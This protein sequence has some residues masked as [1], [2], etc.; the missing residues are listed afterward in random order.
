MTR[1]A[2]AISRAQHGALDRLVLACRHQPRRNQPGQATVAHQQVV[3]EADKEARLAR[4]ALAPGAA[5]QLAVHA[6]ALVAIGPDHQQSAQRQDAGAIGLVGTPQAD[7]GASAGHVGGDGHGAVLAGPR[8]DRRFGRVVRCVQHLARHA[9]IT[10]PRRQAVGLL[11][12]QRAH[13]HRPPAAMFAH[14]FGDDGPVLGLA[15]REDHVGVIDAAGGVVRG[16]HDH[17]AAVG[18][19]QL[20]GRALRGAGHPC[21]RGIAAQEPLQRQRCH[22]LTFGTGHQPLLGIEG[23][24]QALRPSPVRHGTAGHLVDHLDA[25]VAHQ[26]VHA[27]AQQR[28]GVQGAIHLAQPEIVAGLVQ[29]AGAERA[30]DRGQP[31]VGQLRVAPVLVHHEMHTGR[32]PRDDGGQK[33]H[34]IVGPWRARRRLL[35]RRC[36]PAPGARAPRRSAA[37]RPRPPGRRETAG[38]RPRR[39]R[40]RTGRAGDRT[41]IPWR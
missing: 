38:A 34:G 19:M 15:V 12:R 2:R 40:P 5:A 10:N 17:A 36:P 9:G 32:Q 6:T 33:R 28:P 11:H 8:H 13:Q 35:G 21:Q 29:A 37:S 41:R 3:L 23:C 22:D 30:F 39:A 18:V 4:V 1:W 24:L 26:V 14:D 27:A 16:N 7:V 25:A 31:G 20:G